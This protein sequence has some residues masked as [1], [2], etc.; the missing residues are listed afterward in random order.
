MGLSEYTRAPQLRKRKR[1]LIL[2]P[3]YSLSLLVTSVLGPMDPETDVH[4]DGQLRSWSPDTIVTSLF[5]ISY[6]QIKKV[7]GPQ[8]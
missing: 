2:Y 4:P 6:A 1:V 3:Y 7:A 8:G 5:T